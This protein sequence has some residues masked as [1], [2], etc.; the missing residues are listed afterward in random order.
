ME[1]PKSHATSRVLP[2]KNAGKTR[3]LIL[4]EQPL[5]R[6]GISACINSQSDMAA[7]GEADNISDA[8]NK[9]AECKPH[10]L[11]T[12]LRLGR[13]DSLGFVKALKAENPKLLILIYSAFEETIFA[14]RAMRAG[15]VGY[16]M[17]NAPR[18]ELL[19]AI[20]DIVNGGIYVSR[21]VALRTFKG[22]LGARPEKPFFESAQALESLSD[23]EL[24]DVYAEW[25]QGELKSYLIEITA[26]IFSKKDPDTGKALVDL[27]LDAAEQKGT[28]KWTSQNAFDL[29]VPIPTINAAVESRIISAYKQEREAASKE[30]SGPAISFKGDRNRLIH[31]VRDA[32]YLAK[33]CSYAQGMALLRAASKEYGY[34]LKYGAIAAIWRG[35]CIIRAQFL[36]RITDAFRRNPDLPNLLLDEGFKGD[37]EKRQGALREVVRTAIEQGI[38]TL[39]LSSALAYYDAYRTARLPA[40]LTQ[41]QR[42]YFGA[43]TYQRIDKPGVF[44]TEWPS[45]K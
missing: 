10:L 30:L 41:A 42:D 32:L 40:N 8:R 2:G 7:C 34:D 43:H 33:I 14:E 18:E 44:H 13:G 39:A 31:A 19:A 37:V 17:K 23:R 26:D 45:Q 1:T 4:E 5:L 38:P 22:S 20:R 3:I 16:V 12:A 36:N 24:H 15:A 6:D 25:N 9:L 35:G 28:G 21:D 11:L 27:I 29:G